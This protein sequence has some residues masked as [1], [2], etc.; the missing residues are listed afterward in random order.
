VYEEHGHSEKEKG[1]QEISQ[2]SLLPGVPAVLAQFN[3]HGR[4]VAHRGEAYDFVRSLPDNTITLVV[5]SPPYNLGKNMKQ[6]KA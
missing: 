3:P 2:L 1:M 6:S 5:T 4:I